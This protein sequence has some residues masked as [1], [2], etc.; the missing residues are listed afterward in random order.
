MP[1]KPL[2]GRVVAQDVHRAPVGVG[3]PDLAAL[4][5]AGVD[6]V[7][8][9]HRLRVHVLVDVQAE[10]VVDLAAEG[11]GGVQLGPLDEDEVVGGVDRVGARDVVVVGEAEE[12][13]ARAHVPV[14]ALLRSDAAVGVGGV[15]VEVALDPD[16]AVVIRQGVR[17]DQGVRGIEHGNL[18][19]RLGRRGGWS[20]LA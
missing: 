3:E 20:R 17:V 14:E 4:L 16:V 9:R 13:V 15:A 1:A 11:V 6:H 18:S 2:R 5:V 19:K 8:G 7:L 12:V 10:E